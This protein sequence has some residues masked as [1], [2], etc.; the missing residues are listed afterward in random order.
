M[1]EVIYLLKREIGVR[2]AAAF[3]H[4][5]T[6]SQPDLQDVIVDDLRR[7]RQIMLQYEEARFDFVDCCI[8][9]L[10]ERLNITQVCTLDYRDFCI[11]RPVHC[12]YWEILP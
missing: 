8:M 12:D 5:F 11:F 9:A 6:Q 10:A 2:G 3:L 4:E 7:M 1:T